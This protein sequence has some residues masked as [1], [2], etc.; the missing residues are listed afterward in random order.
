M[1]KRA[2]QIRNGVLLGLLC[3]GL[4]AAYFIIS[5]NENPAARGVLFR[6]RNEQITRVS[7]D[8]RLGSFDF[9]EE[10]GAWVVESG[11]VYRTNPEK[12][13]LLLGT[14][15]EFAITRMLT[16]EK[17]EYGFEDPEASVR[18]E[19]SGGDEFRFIV[20]KE[21]ISG[22]S[23]YI[24]S[25]D[26]VMLTS[27]AMTAQLTGS[28]AAYRAKDVLMVDPSQIR[29]IIYFVNG[30]QSLSLSNTDYKS[31]TMDSPLR[32]PA[33]NVILNELVAKLRTLSIAGYIDASTGTT[34]LGLDQPAASMILTDENGVTQT[35]DFGNIADTQ[36]YVRIGGHDDIVALYASDLDFSALT[37]AGVMYLAPLDIPIDQVQSVSI[38]TGGDEDLLTLERNADDVQAAL[39]GRSV[40]YSETF[41]SIYFKC[42]TLNAD[43]YDAS[44]TDPGACEAVC[45]TT[46]LD[47]KTVTLSLYR[48]DAQTLYLYVDGEPVKDGETM[49]YMEE[50]ALNE[51]L[52]RLDNAKGG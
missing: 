23:V 28:L 38:Q 13:D 15:E 10:D 31:W 20:G 14:L 17:S 44:P 29:S 34:D 51:L 16:D 45:S 5:A 22:S 36:Q 42:I 43:G 7:I 8:N 48:R 3:A 2:K 26:D 18:V 52:Y 32:V 24:K 27:T 47:G 35:L 49:F 25:G 6:L 11:G 12:I 50:N 39:N 30:E 4:A 1:T 21:A 19:T 40:S 41:V 46:L 9:H 37:P 33:R